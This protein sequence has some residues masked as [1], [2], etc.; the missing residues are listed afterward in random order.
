MAKSEEWQASLQSRQNQLARRQ[1]QLIQTQVDLDQYQSRLLEI[2]QQVQI[3]IQSNRVLDQLSPPQKLPQ[4]PKN[5]EIF[6]KSSFW[7]PQMLWLALKL[8]TKKALFSLRHQL[9]LSF[10]QHLNNKPQP[11][12]IA[13]DYKQTLSNLYQV[14]LESFLLSGAKLVF[15]T[16]EKPLVSIILVLYN[17]AELT[18]ECLRSLVDVSANPEHPCEIILVD[19][20]SGDDTGMLLERLQGVR[21]IRNTENLHFLLA[22]NQAAHVARGDYLLLLNN[23]AQLLPGAL[24]AAL[25]TIGS[26]NNIGAVGGKIVLLDG[27]LQEAGSIIWND[28]SCLGYGRGDAPFAPPYMFQRDVDYCSGA[29]LLTRREQFVDM[30]GFDEDYKPAYYEETDYCLRLWEQGYR[31]VYDPQVTIVH[32]EFAS[33]RSSDRAI[34]LQSAHQKIFVEKHAQRLRSHLA[35]APEKILLARTAKRQAHRILFIDDRVPHAFLGSGFPRARDIL[36]SLVDLDCL[37]TFYPLTHPH[38]S[39]H[40]VYQDLPRTIEVMVEWGTA[41][42][43][44]FWQQRAGFYHTI[45]V[46]RPHN[47]QRF[48]PLLNRYRQRFE[49]TRIIYDAEA[50][51]ALRE[52]KQRSVMGKKVSA[53]EVKMLIEAELKLAQN[54]DTIIAVSEQ[55]RQ[56]FLQAGFDSVTTLGHTVAL[57]PTAATFE[58]RTGILFVGAIHDEKSP[59]A[60]SLFWFVQEVL[61]RIQDQ[62]GED[63]RFAI[64]GFNKSQKLLSLQ[65]DSVQILG[66]VEQLWELYNSS[67]IFVAPTRF[68]AGIPFKVHHAAAHGLPI[69]TTSLIA[70]QLGW[71]DRTEVLV[72]DDPKTFAQQCVQL[73]SHQPL[74]QQ[75]REQAL[76]RIETECSRSAFLRQ[77]REVLQL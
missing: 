56:H 57:T 25:R 69:V 3:T 29:F 39:W 53:A 34:A 11:C 47:M 27:S 44:A 62:L 70:H 68:A 41:G 37:V 7:N 28:G 20:A 71:Q 31:I 5:R 40:T 6:V 60:D 12:A 14:A 76:K 59:N 21:V 16:Q 51:Y 55:E 73:Y 1:S 54:A 4:S 23:D 49:H 19:N 35:P 18:F 30:G 50:L 22:V 24:A 52:V 74:W 38:E 33:S 61:P 17:R 43:E 63:I 65:S 46:S 72:G 13:P 48:A 8:R 67:R 26:A 9:R 45:V 15:P 36:Q 10:Q 64:A 32:F 66:K 58:E 75:L 2:Q 77:L 42:L